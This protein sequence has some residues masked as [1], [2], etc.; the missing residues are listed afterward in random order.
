MA[1]KFYKE[2][3]ALNIVFETDADYCREVG[4]LER[5][6]VY[7][8]GT[9][10]GQVTASGI[11][12]PHDPD[13]EDGRETE[14]ALLIYRQPA[15]ETEPVTGPIVSAALLKRGPASVGAASLV[16]HATINTV[17]EIAAQDA[18]LMSL[19]GIRVRAQG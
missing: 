4:T 10:L 7:K 6:H 15:S 1:D 19:L 13:A 11:Y 3:V 9:I 17:G 12:A 16:R 8:A 14:A 5:G 18:A 2:P